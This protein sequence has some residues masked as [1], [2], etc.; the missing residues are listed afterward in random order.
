MAVLISFKKRKGFSLLEVLIAIMVINV[1]VFASVNLM[2]FTLNNWKTTSQKLQNTLTAQEKLEQVRNYRDNN[3]TNWAST[4]I[5]PHGVTI[6][7]GSRTGQQIISV[8]EGGVN[9]TYQLYDWR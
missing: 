2:T 3:P 6:S 7:P 5:P 8:N 9:I 1:G 4:I